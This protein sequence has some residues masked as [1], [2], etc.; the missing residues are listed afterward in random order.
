MSQVI[1]PL[2]FTA[3]TQRL[4][5]NEYVDSPL[6]VY[7]W[8]AG[9]GGGPGDG[10][11]R[12]GSGGGGLGTLGGASPASGAGADLAFSLADW[13]AS[14]RA[15]FGSGAALA[16]SLLTGGAGVPPLP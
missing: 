16:R 9:G 4:I 1:R 8:G 5:I 2:G 14:A 10:Y 7:L 11:N 6:T 15:A 13:L 3:T 12:G